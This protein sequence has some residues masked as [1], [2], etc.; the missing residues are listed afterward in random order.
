MEELATLMESVANDKAGFVSEVFEDC[1][2]MGSADTSVNH[3]TWGLNLFEGIFTTGTKFS[4]RAVR[5]DE[6]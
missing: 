5:N 3:E 4:I 1:F 2:G 6:N